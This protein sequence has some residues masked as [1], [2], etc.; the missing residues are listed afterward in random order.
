MAE[1]KK[2]IY[3]NLDAAVNAAA[4][5]NFDRNVRMNVEDPS[6]NIPDVYYKEARALLLDIGENYQP[7]LP[8]V[9]WIVYQPMKE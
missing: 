4:K 5:Q 6:N 3:V 8:D 2:K 9:D 1:M 7:E